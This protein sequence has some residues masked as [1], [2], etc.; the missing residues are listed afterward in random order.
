VLD[1]VVWS[2]LLAGF[3]L[4]AWWG[5]SRRIS[6]MNEDDDVLSREFEALLDN[7]GR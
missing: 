5:G 4:G 2:A 3:L 7:N 6:E 1:A